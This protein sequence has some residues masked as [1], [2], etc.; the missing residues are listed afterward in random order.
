MFCYSD[1]RIKKKSE[2]LLNNKNNKCFFS[3][4]YN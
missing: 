2:T 3:Y 4:I 1:E